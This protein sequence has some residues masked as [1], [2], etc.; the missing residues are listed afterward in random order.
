MFKFENGMVRTPDGDNLLPFITEWRMEME[1]SSVMRIVCEAIGISPQ[2]ALAIGCDHPQQ[3]F[4]PKFLIFKS[5]NEIIIP[6]SGNNIY[7]FLHNLYVSSHPAKYAENVF[8]IEGS[9]DIPLIYNLSFSAYLQSSTIPQLKPVHI[10]P[11]DN[12]LLS[13]VSS[14]VM[15]TEDEYEGIDFDFDDDSLNW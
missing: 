15:F 5:V 13:M 2:L 14:V 10:V 9:Q 7:P 4:L 11:S 8:K 3:S 12:E 1:I 6:T